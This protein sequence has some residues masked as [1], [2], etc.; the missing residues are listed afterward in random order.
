MVTTYWK[1]RSYTLVDLSEPLQL[2]RRYLEKFATGR[3]RSLGPMGFI[4]ADEDVQSTFDLC[5]SNYAFTEL[6][7]AA[8]G[9]YLRMVVGPSSA[10]YMTCNFISEGF[11]ISSMSPEELLAMHPESTWLPEEPLSHPENR[12]LVWGDRR[13]G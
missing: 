2:A 6:S 1:V 10:G 9:R 5:I 3:S 12:I 8:Q 13:L 4:S 11:G 7:R